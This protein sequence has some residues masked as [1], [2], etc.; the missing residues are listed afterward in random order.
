MPTLIFQLGN[1]PELSKRELYSLLP[2]VEFTQIQDNLLSADISEYT[3]EHLMMNLGGTVKIFETISEVTSNDDEAIERVLLEELEKKSGKITF[4]IAELGRDHLP[5]L[6]VRTLKDTLTKQGRSVR[7][8]EDSRSGL[9]SAILSHKKSLI[10]L[11][12]IQTHEGTIIAKTVGIQDIDEWSKIDRQKPYADRKKGMLPPKV[13]RM[14]VNM[15]VGEKIMGDFDESFK[16]YDPFCGSGT[17]LLEAIILG[18]KNILASD[19]DQDSV[20]GTKKNIEWL[21]GMYQTT[22]KVHVFT[23]DVTRPLQLEP[24]SI[25]CIVTEPFL[26]KPT[27]RPEQIENIFKGLERLYLGAFKQWAPYLADGATICI[28]FPRT[29]ATV[30]N[31]KHVYTLKNLIDKL[32][33]IGYTTQSESIMYFRPQAMIQREIYTFVYRSAKI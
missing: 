17:V 23:H 30:R 27:P 22:P 6:S 29:E 25:N 13:A 4:A 2:N 18:I 9:S 15:A 11:A 28:V 16:I 26:G 24:R 1:T 19:L 8:I 7:Y 33:K 21:L 31:H 12:L 10:E 32:A 3:T 5:K 20:I 14:M